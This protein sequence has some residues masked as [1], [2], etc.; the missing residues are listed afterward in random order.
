MIG[1]LA[2]DC[3]KTH[4]QP[5]SQMTPSVILYAYVQAV[6]TATQPAPVAQPQQVLQLIFVLLL[7]LMGAVFKTPRGLWPMWGQWVLF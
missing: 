4:L 3:Q 7:L 1:W 6:A 5:L 2:S